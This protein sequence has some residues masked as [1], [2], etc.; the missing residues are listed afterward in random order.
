MEVLHKIN[1]VQIEF[2]VILLIL[3]RL[4]FKRMINIQTG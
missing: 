1:V 3:S 2:Y 4:I